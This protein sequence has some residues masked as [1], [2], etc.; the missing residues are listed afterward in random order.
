M[1]HIR[2]LFIANA[3]VWIGIGAYLFMLGRSQR[4]LSQRLKHLEMMRDDSE[5]A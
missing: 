3:A 5:K 4:Q 1:D 2:F